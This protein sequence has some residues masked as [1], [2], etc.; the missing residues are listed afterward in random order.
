MIDLEYCARLFPGVKTIRIVKMNLNS[1][2]YNSILFNFL[3]KTESRR[4]RFPYKFIWNRI[5]QSTRNWT[6]PVD[7]V[8]HDQSVKVS[9]NYAY[10]IFCRQFKHWNNPLVELVN[11]AHK[12]LNRPITIVDV[13]AAIGDTSLLI[14]A[15]CPGMVG[16]YICVDG[17]PEF[18]AYLEY[19]LASI[20][21][22]KKILHQ[23]SSSHKKDKSLVRTHGGTA[24]AQGV[25]QVDASPLDDVLNH[26]NVGNVD[27]L[28]I[29]VDGFDGE[30]LA[31]S[32]K[33]LSQFKPFVI[34]E[35]HPKLC[36]QTS[37]D[38]F[39][40]FEVLASTG[41]NRLIWFTKYGEFSHYG[42]SDDQ[43]NL[44]RMKRHCMTTKS[45]PDCHF[46]IVAFH[47]SHLVSEQD[48]ADLQFAIHKKSPF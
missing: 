1:K 44:H 29:D 24:S 34:F 21:N 27:L 36:L 30:V 28:K 40:G 48:T 41:Y 35:W 2:I 4:R 17:D 6:M 11:Q 18:Y 15:N 31:G 9:F 25:D 5:Y 23:L 20:P 16:E 12:S 7:T 26:H 22:S 37:N 46:D 43:V 47:D 13:G 19:N 10:P 38:A 39:R 8:I 33:L 45:D 32:T 3:V 42:R 14:H